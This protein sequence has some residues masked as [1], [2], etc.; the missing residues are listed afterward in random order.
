MKRFFLF[1]LVLLFTHEQLRS[2]EVRIIGV[3]SGSFDPPTTAHQKIILAALEK[4]RFD[5]LI[6]Y[7]NQFGKKPYHAD[8]SH[9]K[10]MLEIMLR[11]KA[12]LVSVIIQTNADKRIDYRKIREPGTLLALII[13]EDS[14]FKRLA[15][16]EIQKIPVEEIY[17]VPRTSEFTALASALAPKEH[18]MYIPNIQSVSSTKTRKQLISGIFSEIN[19]HKDVLE[20]IHANHLYSVGTKSYGECGKK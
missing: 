19:L 1:F 3:F 15:L 7:V 16:P 17:V 2:D 13:G 20:Y 10:K 4:Q 6:I 12:D 11:D 14:Y 18:I 8:P 9:R 5:K